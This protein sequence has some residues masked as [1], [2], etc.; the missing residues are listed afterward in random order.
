MV[1]V[2]QGL[3]RQ[4]KGGRRRGRSEGRG[5]HVGDV[6]DEPKGQSSNEDD[7]QNKSCLFR[8]LFVVMKWS[9]KVWWEGGRIGG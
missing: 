1:L 3:D 8:Q 6:G 4:R 7:W 9:R 2:L 5:K